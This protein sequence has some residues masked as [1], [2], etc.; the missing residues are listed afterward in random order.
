MHRFDHHRRDDGAPTEDPER[1]ILYLA[2][3]MR[4]CA[5]ELFGELG[6]ARIC[7][8]TR[9]AA[10][11]PDQPTRLQDLVGPGAMTIGAR[12]SLGS[13]DTPR[14]T[15][16]EWA[17]AIYED[18]PSGQ[19]T[20]VRFSSHW[21]EGECMALW[22]TAPTVRVLH[23]DRL[24]GP[25]WSHFLVAANDVHVS[26][27]KIPQPECPRCIDAGLVPATTSPTHP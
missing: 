21:E 27:R 12:T 7:P 16:Q 24:D 6:E 25:P 26:A 11:S 17:R 5:A 9:I 10:I 15:T 2:E 1:T 23:D 3:F 4:T 22:D 20:G 14:P 18:N 13:G 8:R 19:A